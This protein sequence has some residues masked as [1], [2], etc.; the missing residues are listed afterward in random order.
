MTAEQIRQLAMPTS[1]VCA[2][3][4]PHRALRRTAVRGLAPTVVRTLIPAITAHTHAL[5]SDIDTGYPVEFRSAFARP[6]VTRVLAEV[7]SVPGEHRG[8]FTEWIDAMTVVSGDGVTREALHTHA[9]GAAKLSDCLVRRIGDLSANPDG[10]SLS[11][12][13]TH[14]APA[15]DLVRISHA[16]VVAAHTPLARFLTSVIAAL[17]GDTALEKSVRADIPER[18][19]H[20]VDEVLRCHSP[21]ES[22]YRTAIHGTVLSG[23]RVA[24]GTPVRIR[25][26]AANRDDEVFGDADQIDLDR[27]ITPRHLGFGFGAH[28]CVGADLVRTVSIIAISVIMHRFGAM[29]IDRPPTDAEGLEHGHELYV[30]FAAHGR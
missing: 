5:A 20:L 29:E 24:P 28:S 23:V 25:L 8:D 9:D 12:M 19:P 11:A 15:A 6:L 13:V 22:T 4:T 27:P 21:V 3:G 26:S 7:L 1:L 18:T 2:D 30:T 17:A 14:S 10:S 16:L